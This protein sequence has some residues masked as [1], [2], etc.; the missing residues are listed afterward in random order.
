MFVCRRLTGSER[1]SSK[2]GASSRSEVAGERLLA[3]TL[4]DGILYSCS[5]C[6]CVQNP[7]FRRSTSGQ[8][9]SVTLRL[10]VIDPE[11]PW[12]STTAPNVYPH[13]SSHD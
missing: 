1:I 5:A 2:V 10:D 13:F 11:H 12:L 8:G 6:N 4:G 7:M 9:V 3:L